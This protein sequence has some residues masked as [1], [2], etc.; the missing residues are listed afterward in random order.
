MSQPEGRTLNWMQRTEGSDLMLSR[1]LAVGTPSP[2]AAQLYFDGRF[3][4]VV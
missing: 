2:Q 4:G 1:L 3:S